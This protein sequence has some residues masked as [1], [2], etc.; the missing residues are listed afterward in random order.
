MSIS[1]EFLAS[2]VDTLTD[3]IAVI[4]RQ[5]TILYVNRN[6]CLFSQEN[7]YREPFQWIGKN[8]L[9]VCD[10]PGQTVDSSAYEAAEGIRSVISKDADNYY[11][12]YPCDSPIEKRWF[13]M[14]ALRFDLNGESFVVVSHS[15][16]TER[17]LAEEQVIHLSRVDTV[18]GLANRRYFEEW[19]A[20]Q[21]AHSVREQKHL[22]LAL[23]DID[24]FKVLNDTLGHQAGDDC[25]KTVSRELSGLTRR[26]D[27]LAVRYGGDELM[28]IHGNTGLDESLPLLTELQSRIAALEI[29]NP[30]APT[31]PGASL[32]IGLASICPG[33]QDDPEILIRRADQLLYDAKSKG[34]DRIESTDLCERD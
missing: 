25:L 10:A 3:H 29:P 20:R 4:D 21:W 1:Y 33:R 17:K 13:L 14:R 12:E 18:T 24:H 27:D 19:F 2:L 15:N 28:I 7:E 16:I 26:P 11:L 5:G 31:G 32:S 8:Y 23:I 6:W 30:K 9:E 34:R 22:S